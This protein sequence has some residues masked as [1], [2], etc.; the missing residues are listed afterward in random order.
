M[1]GMLIKDMLEEE[2]PREKACRF[3]IRTLSTAELLA[4]LLR[5]GIKGQSV[6]DTSQAL[7]RKAKNVSGLAS[8]SLEEIMEIDGIG[9]AKGL[10][11]LAS[12]ELARRMAFDDVKGEQIKS[13]ASLV[14]WLK[15][16][17]GTQL[18][19]MF[20]VVYLNQQLRIITHRILFQGT[21]NEAAVYP[22]EIFKEALLL[23]STSLMFAHNHPGGD[24]TPSSADIAL[25]AKLMKVADLMG[26]KVLDHIIV[27]GN[28]YFSFARQGILGECMTETD[29]QW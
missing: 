24:I 23:N 15:S 19:E 3:G 11:L 27:S 9:E 2:K 18:Q 20:L 13:P 10:V 4:I 6:L 28:D 1:S 14:N 29:N 5:T 16:E 22:R 21:I 7:L 25:T 26:V 12:F 8:M 17:I